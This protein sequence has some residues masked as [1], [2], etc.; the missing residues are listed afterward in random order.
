LLTVSTGADVMLLVVTA[1]STVVRSAAAYDDSVIIAPPNKKLK[2]L[3]AME[4]SEPASTSTDDYA[5]V[6]LHK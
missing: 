4:P 2:I 3:A 5:H 1:V 6:I